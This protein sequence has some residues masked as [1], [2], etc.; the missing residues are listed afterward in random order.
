MVL[1]LQ[2]YVKLMVTSTISKHVKLPLLL[3]PASYKRESVF[4]L[5]EGQ[6]SPRSYGYGTP[7]NI[8]RRYYFDSVTGQAVKN[9]YVQENDGWYYYGE[10]GNAIRPQNGEANI[11][12][13]IVLPLCQWSSG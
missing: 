2:E 7:I 5:E 11:D 9:R 6:N 8:T 3:I 4:L 1:N 12:G 10:D 13:Q